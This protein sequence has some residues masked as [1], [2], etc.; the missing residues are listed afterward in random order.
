MNIINTP[1]TFNRSNVNKLQ[2]PRTMSILRFMVIA[3]RPLLIRELFAKFPQIR[4]N[5]MGGYLCR[6][7]HYSLIRVDKS[8]GRIYGRPHKNS[9]SEDRG[10][11]YYVK[12]SKIEDINDYMTRRIGEDWREEKYDNQ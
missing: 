4:K 1:V 10:Y 8:R 7:I 3:N 2:L 5:N 6:L 9:L 12:P 11:L